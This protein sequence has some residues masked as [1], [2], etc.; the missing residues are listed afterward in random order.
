MKRNSILIVGLLLAALRSSLMADENAP[1]DSPKIGN[2]PAAKVLFL[3]PQTPCQPF[4]TQR[5][6]LFP[7]LIPLPSL[8]PLTRSRSFL[9]PT[10]DL[11]IVQQP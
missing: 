8:L 10:F 1:S 9:C 5:M 3:D 11:S 4:K 2:L 7:P 6:L